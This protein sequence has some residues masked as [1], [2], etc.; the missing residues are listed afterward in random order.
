VPSDPLPAA[1]RETSW[2]ERYAALKS[3]L[4]ATR[5]ALDRTQQALDEA[6]QALHASAEREQAA[7]NALTTL[8]GRLQRHER[9]VLR[10]DVLADLLPARARHRR[11]TAPD[12]A[13]RRR[14]AAHS[15]VSDAYAAARTAEAPPGA[16]RV[17]IGGVTWWVPADNRTGGQ[18]ADRVLHRRH[19]PLQDILRTR[20]AISNG[21]MIDVGANIGLTSVTRA[22]LGDASLIYAA[23][24]A[25]EN[26]ACLVRTVVDNGL[27]G[28]VLPDR[29]AISDR[30]GTATLRISGSIGG[31]ALREGATG[32]DVPTMRLDTWIRKLGIDA[33][34][35]CYVKVDTQG[36][37]S[38]VMDGAP[39]LLART[40]VAWELEFAPSLL[41]K[42]GR[43]VAAVMAQLQAAFTHFIDLNGSAPG[44]R[45]RLVAELPEA[46]A[47]L[48]RGFTNLLLYRAN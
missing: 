37:E 45:R 11:E 46:V 25:P 18:L 2:K 47:Y 8:H 26:F 43:D 44:A 38:H 22:I 12:E 32:I 1:T 20:E 34:T 48:E 28:I 6:R 24:P 3:R 33:A 15:S 14:D 35:V 31:H 39:D 36:Y 7:R 29:V 40:G 27:Q 17:E 23:E 16:D 4:G 19:L 9:Q 21:T 30:D 10:P 5:T 41:A 13:T 42:V